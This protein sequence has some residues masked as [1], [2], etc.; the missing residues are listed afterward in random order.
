VRRFALWTILASSFLLPPFLPPNFSS[1]NAQKSVN[2]DRF[3]G[4]AELPRVYVKSE[5]ADTPATGKSVLVKTSDELKAA[6]D[7]AA[8]GDTIRLQV[9]AVFAGNFKLPAKNCDDSHWIILRS[10]APDSDLPP[11]GTRITPC[12]ANVA[13][14][15][16]R[17][18]YSC[19]RPSNVM[20]K[21][22]LVGKGG[23]GPISL[24]SGA[25]HYR[26]VGLEITRDS[27]G[28]EI[29]GLAVLQDKGATA[30]HLVFDRV[31]MHG[32]AQDETTRGIALGGSQYV[33]VVDSYFSDFHCVAV[34]G[35]CIDAQAIAGGLGD[36]PMG[37][38]KIVNNFL[39]A[40]GENI[41]F[42]GGAATLTPADIEIRH[43]HL[44]KPL[45]WKSGNP[46][47]VGGT[48]GKPFIVK[49]L[50][51]IKNA[52]RVLLEGNVMEN[53]WGGFTQK[54]F[55]I[56]L[57]PKNQ[58]NRCPLCKST[59]I[60]I[61]LNH[62]AHVASGLQVGSGL[63]DAGG[64][65]SG[66]ERVSIHDNIFDDIDGKEYGGFGAFAQITSTFPALRDINISHNTA[67]PSKALL[68]LGVGKDRDRI[69]NFVFTNNLVG[70][71]EF[72]I[73]STGGGENNC[74]FRPRVQGIAGVL[75]NCFANASVTRNVL[76]GSQGGWPD[77]NFYAP[78]ASSLV[79]DF[80]GGKGG[81]YRLC[82]G[83]GVR[84]NKPA[85]FLGKGLD[86]RNPG[87]DVDAVEATLAG[88]K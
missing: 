34:T 51:E 20:A 11:E 28:R 57:T 46:G 37:P 16:G 47:F 21:V 13:F 56:L 4:P 76:I 23:V 88:V 18:P 78:D 35:S 5:V 45:S 86:E 7:K 41:L 44:F 19:S 79:E 12:Y 3:D 71:A 17:P 42:G 33:A 8:C 55:G 9:G 15:P 69:V 24:G 61:R 81:N 22:V 85:A 74:A 80:R 82:K 39:E 75:G 6:L 26:L 32:T 59:D 14:L 1:G 67:F 27:D 43:N 53:S 65:A 73:F 87:A 83:K 66:S 63:S 30:D 77:G 58:S 40:S 2:R 31:W 48:S 52:Q 50:F 84:C 54:G 60:V 70:V 68:L 49:N 25:N 64:A 38:Y 72:D 29:H 10:S 62:I 36:R